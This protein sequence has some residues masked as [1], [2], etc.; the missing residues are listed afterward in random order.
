MFSL[1][2]HRSIHKRIFTMAGPIIFANMSQPLLGIA[3]NAV[4]GHLD[5]PHYL[6]GVA[7]GS[8]IFSLIYWGFGFLRM[9]TTGPVAQARGS[10]NITEMGAIFLRGSVVAIGFAALLLIFHPFIGAL[11]LY[12]MDPGDLVAEQTMIYYKIRIFSAP[13]TLWIY[14]VMGWFLG[15][16]KSL[17]PFL[18]QVFGHGLNI[19]LSVIF[20][21]SFNWDVAGVA[22]ATVIAE[23]AI[24]GLMM[25]LVWRQ[26]RRAKVPRSK[27]LFTSQ[28][29]KNLFV[30][31]GNIFIRTWLLL[32]ALA[33]FTAQSARYGDV[34]LAANTILLQFVYLSAF[35]LDGFA[36]TAEAITGRSIG[37]KNWH[38][39]RLELR[40]TFFWAALIAVLITFIYT[41]F[42]TSFIALI[43]NIDAV[44]LYTKNYLFW[45]AWIPIISVWCYIWDGV[46][47]GAV[48]TTLLRNAIICSVGLYVIMVFSFQPLWGNH[49]LWLALY[50]LMIARAGSL[51]IGWHFYTVPRNKKI[52]HA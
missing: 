28:A 43:T 46:F 33:L 44:R 8:V 42:G 38:Q 14:V 2:K 49:G 35:A 13:A 32:F 23:Y 47:L 9:G 6:G 40:L 26:W 18:I 4:T 22:G 3:D 52:H 30:L 29:L 1:Q 51:W 45:V 39:L 19:L 11:A 21:F 15:Q 7:I 41:I 17:F 34:G 48:E 5:A 27:I 25:I 16:E 24:L 36:F 37:A 50:G 12:V 10:G 20:V 31:S